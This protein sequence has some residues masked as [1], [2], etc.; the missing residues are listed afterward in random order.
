MHIFEQ[1]E[2]N[3]KRGSKMQANGTEV[4]SELGIKRE[5][6][7]LY[8]LRGT[9]VWKAPLKRPGKSVVS[10]VQ[11]VVEGK[12]ERERGFLYYINKSGHVARVKARVGGR[13]RT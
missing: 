5:P 11:K 9:D 6:G 1:N 12:F 2:A 7:F 4:V 8:F 13:K 10:E 3:N